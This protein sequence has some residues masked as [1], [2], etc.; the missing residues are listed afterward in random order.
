MVV[1]LKEY[2][3]LKRDGLTREQIPIDYTI[4]INYVPLSYFNLI[5]NFQFSVPIYVV[6]FMLISSIVILTIVIFWLV[7]LSCVKAKDP[8]ALRFFQLAKITFTNPSVGCFL[9]VIPVGFSGVLMKMFQTSTLFADQASNWL[10]VGMIMT[11]KDVVNARRGR[12][13]L[14]FVIFGLIFMHFGA[15]CI[16]H[17]PS[18]PEEREIL[19]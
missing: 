6:L 15:N 16:V 11:V 19:A 3:G 7:T 9:S 12:I 13:G 18:V 1:Y 8:P 2:D 5:N 4:K 10:E 14:M 17:K